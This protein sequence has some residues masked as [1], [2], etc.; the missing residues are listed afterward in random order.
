ML[1]LGGA[2]RYNG[3]L[4]LTKTAK[5]VTQPAH[6]NIHTL[7]QHMI[8]VCEKNGGIGLAA[9]QVGTLLQVII[10]KHKDRYY[11]L[12]NPKIHSMQEPIES[13]EGCLSLPGEQ[14]MVNRFKLIEVG[15]YNQQGKHTRQFFHGNP[16][17]IILHEMDHLKGI[18]LSMSGKKVK[19]VSTKEI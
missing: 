16:A 11:E 19:D 4:V 10:F 14:Y 3:D 18:T 15:F 8:K 2:L 13:L 9:P 1:A 7:I 5:K 6:T 12:I 17:I